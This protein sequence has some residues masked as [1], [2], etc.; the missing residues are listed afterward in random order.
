MPNDTD[1][2]QDDDAEHIDDVAELN[3]GDRVLVDDRSQPQ[4]VIA[5]GHRDI[6]DPVYGTVR[7]HYVRVA[8][9]W[10]GAAEFEYATE[11][12]TWTLEPTGNVV[13]RRLGRPRDV[14]RVATADGQ[15]P[16]EGEPTEATA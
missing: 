1:Q 11:L 10:D 15:T 8:G 14:R 16:D 13:D 3:Q 2:Q 9:E 7:Q 4:T 12:D 6:N 5:T